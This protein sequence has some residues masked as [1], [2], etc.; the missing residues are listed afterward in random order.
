MNRLV[1]AILALLSAAAVAY[2]FLGPPR[3]TGAPQ[4]Q[5]SP[6]EGRQSQSRPAP[7]ESGPFEEDGREE[8]EGEEVGAAPRL[9]EASEQAEVPAGEAAS[10]DAARARNAK[11]SEEASREP[12]RFDVVRVETTGRLVAAGRAAP[13]AA[14]ELR[15]GEL[16]VDQV[17]AD[18]RGEWVMLPDAALPPGDHELTLV[19]RDAG[20]NGAVAAA[21]SGAVIV[22]VPRQMAGL[23][24]SGDSLDTAVQDAE[25]ELSAAP[26]EV[27]PAQPLAVLLPDDPEEA[28]RILQGP[29]EGLAVGDL[30]LES[31]S[32]DQ[33][34]YLTIDGRVTPAGRVFVYIDNTFFDETAG[35]E[36]G[37]WRS[38]PEE[39]VAEG[40]HHLRLDQVD[41]AGQVLAR[42]ETPFV[43]S[44]FVGGMS[45][46]GHFVVVQPGN[47]LWR[48]ARGTNGKGIQYTLIFDAN[49][50]QIGDPDLI[51]PGQI[52]LLPRDG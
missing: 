45:P 35:D 41:E 1:L 43:R 8:G 23:P 12:A 22:S 17:E 47:S 26:E 46:D 9:P 16:L 33:E 21:G 44:D 27:A 3:N 15:S 18:Q 19:V 4:P 39:P 48:I 30:S 28:P 34:G 7:A 37:R 32:Y 2:Y 11:T 29:K 51:Y 14:V 42:L 38:R 40:L 25:E 31:L 24:T 50:D 20:Q 5:V 49:R 52:F 13:G 36:D 6:T 10:E